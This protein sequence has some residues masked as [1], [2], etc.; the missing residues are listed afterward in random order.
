MRCL[1]CYLL[2]VIASAFAAASV[3]QKMSIIAM[4]L[5]PPASAIDAA[6]ARSAREEQLWQRGGVAHSNW[7]VS[8]ASLLHRDRTARHAS[9]AL[10]IQR[11]LDQCSLSHDYFTAV[12]RA[13]IG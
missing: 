10:L 6:Q 3:P 8:S 1:A 9:S 12:D 5:A 7:L 2:A 11:L 4:R 13:A